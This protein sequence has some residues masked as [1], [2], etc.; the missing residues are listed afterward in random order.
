M[1]TSH[2]LKAATEAADKASDCALTTW[3]LFQVMFVLPKVEDKTKRNTDAKAT[4]KIL[5]DKGVKIGK[6]LGEKLAELKG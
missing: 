6:S 3:A 2:L 5:K 4:E 1:A